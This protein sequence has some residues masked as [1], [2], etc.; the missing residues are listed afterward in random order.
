[1][2]R[3]TILIKKNQPQKGGFANVAK[4]PPPRLARGSFVIVI[5]VTMASALIL[6]ESCLAIEGDLQFA[7]RAS[8]SMGTRRADRPALARRKVA[9]RRDQGRAMAPLSLFPTIPE[10][11]ALY[12]ERP[13]ESELNE[14]TA[15]GGLLDLR[16]GLALPGTYAQAEN[17]I[18]QNSPLLE[19]DLNETPAE[20]G[21]RDDGDEGSNLNLKLGSDSNQKRPVEGAKAL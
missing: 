18:S 5:V 9:A 19:Q 15:P 13:A 17:E 3:N 2:I 1:M 21:D 16:L 4:D 14:S 11:L 20:H 7:G 8:F 12:N 6:T 10:H